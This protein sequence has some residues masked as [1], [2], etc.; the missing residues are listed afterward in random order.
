MSFIY[1]LTNP[2]FPD[3]VK[4]GMTDNIDERLHSLN[5]KSAVPFPFHLHALMEFDDAYQAEQDIHFLIDTIN[6]GLRSRAE[7]PNGKERIREFFNISP[8][9]AEMII[10]K[11]AEIKGVKT[12]LKYGSLSQEQIQ[13][14][15]KTAKKQ[16]ATFYMLGIPVGSTLYYLRDKS[17]TCIVRDSENGVTYNDQQRTLSSISKE[18]LG[19]AINGFMMFTYENET[20]WDRRIRLSL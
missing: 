11:Y 13:E 15:E 12:E 9:K 2:S 10:K 18:L 4:I 1:I 20:L 8:E 14:N 6:P 16:P 19:Y 5:S 3:W 17:I 7:L